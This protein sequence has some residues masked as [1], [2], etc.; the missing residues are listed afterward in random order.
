MKYLIIINLVLLS[1]N[2]CNGQIQLEKTFADGEFVVSQNIYFDPNQNTDYLLTFDKINQSLNFYDV[3]Y[4]LYK[5]LTNIFDGNQISCM[6]TYLTRNLFNS[7]NKLEFLAIISNKNGVNTIKLINED[8][9]VL[10]DFGSAASAYCIKISNKIKL[11]VNTVEISY[12]PANPGAKYTSHFYS[13][14]GKFD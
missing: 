2:T 11:V 12:D 4:N 1:F 13:V 8:G 7:D 6:P 14:P 9:E 3:D 5:S 10:K